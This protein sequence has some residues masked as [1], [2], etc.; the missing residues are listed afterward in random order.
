MKTT[1][2]G[3][4]AMGGLVG[5]IM[6]E[7]GE[8]VQLVDIW[9]EHVTAIKK[10]GLR[11]EKDGQS[12]SIP[13]DIHTDYRQTRPA[14]LVI[15]FTKGYDTAAAALSAREILAPGGVVLTLQNGLGNAEVLAETLPSDVI[16]TGTTAY[17]GT[18]LGLGHVL[19]GGAGLTHIGAFAGVA[20]EKVDAVADLLNR[21]GMTTEVQNDVDA[22]VWT[23]FL[24]NCSANAVVALCHMNNGDMMNLPITRELSEGLLDEGLAV[25]RALNIDIRSDIVD[26]YW[27]VIREVGKNRASMGQD[28]DALRRTE[29]ETLNG[30]IVRLGKEKGI[31]TPLNF[32][33]TALIKTWEHHYLTEK[34]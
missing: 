14:D 18:L 22:L 28:V 13:L 5:G 34:R 24:L 15:V 23:K 17:A 9:E 2:L 21:V 33:V 6:T 26:Y 16:I 10:N 27:A 12:R 3:A 8:D 25:A 7:R 29:I 32:A 31:P 1:F 4:G 20:K 19:H 30:A 11:I